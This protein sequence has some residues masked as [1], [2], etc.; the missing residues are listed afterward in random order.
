MGMDANLEILQQRGNACH[1][2]IPS[3]GWAQMQ[4][5]AP[6]KGQEEN[7]SPNRL[8]KTELLFPQSCPNL[9][10]GAPAGA[11]ASARSCAGSKMLK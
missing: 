7:L 5:E 4:E 10:C 8:G 1:Q 2:L 9:T 6:F 3:L 11:P